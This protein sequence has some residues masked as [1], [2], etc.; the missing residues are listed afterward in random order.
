[1]T[2]N[3]F[4]K[5]A[6]RRLRMSLSSK[7]S[8]F[9]PIQRKT[10]VLYTMGKVASSSL[11]AGF[12]R[13][14]LPCHHIHNLNLEVLLALAKPSIDAGCLP[15]KHVSQSMAHKQDYRE[16]PEQFLFIS[17]ARD[18]IARN[19]SA[20]F[21]NL[22]ISEQKSG[23]KS[24]V[25]TLLKEFNSAYPHT[26][27]LLWF[28]KQ[29][30]EHLDIDIYQHD[31]DKHKKYLYLPTKNT[32]LFRIDCPRSDKEKILSKLFKRSIFIPKINVGAR[33]DYSE[34]Y[35]AFKANA[36]FD[37]KFLNQTYNSDYCRYFWTEQERA[38]MRDSWAA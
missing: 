28:D 24:D 31:F 22:Y 6:Q 21:Q 33:K 35:K 14:G 37:E 17:L 13:A 26:L 8:P 30:R 38:E 19:I 3:S 1:M 10:P 34:R 20:F 32:L 23:E 5:K 11:T 36:K 9:K 29:F 7:K 16:H 12:N 25:N 4:A 2:E 15:L 27:P 18:P